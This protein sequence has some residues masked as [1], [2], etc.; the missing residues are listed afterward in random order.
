MAALKAL[1]ALKEKVAPSLGV[2]ADALVAA[3]GKIQVKDTPSKE[4]VVGGGVQADRPAAGHA[5]E[6]GRPA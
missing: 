1:E 5:R 4:P 6:T 2:T 3:G